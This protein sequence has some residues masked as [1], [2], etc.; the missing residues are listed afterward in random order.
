MPQFFYCNNKVISLSEKII[1]EPRIAAQL[2]CPYIQV[3]EIAHL[4]NFNL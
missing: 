3:G 4:K 2:V 1:L